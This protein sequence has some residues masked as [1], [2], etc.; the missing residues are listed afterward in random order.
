[1]IGRGSYTILGPLGAGGMGEVYRARDSKLGRDVAIKILPPHLLDDQERRARFTREA[2]LLATLNHPH[3]GAIYG[4]E[5]AQGLTALVLE[6]VEGLTLAGHLARGPLPIADAVAIA[7]QI[8]E[9]LEAAHHKGIVHRDLKPANIALHSST[10]AAGIPSSVAFVKVLDFGLAKT[11]A[12]GAHE[13]ITQASFDATAEGRVLGTPA[14]MSPEQARGQGVDKRTDIWAF[15]CVLYEMLTGR[16]AFD[17]DTLSDTFVSILE[18]EPDWTALPAQTPA[19]VRLLLQR[20]LRKDPGRRLHDIADARIELE[21]SEAPA[22][23][24]SPTAGAAPGRSRQRQLAWLTAALVTVAVL[25]A[26]TIAWMRW[27]RAPPAADRVEFV[28]APPDGWDFTGSSFAIAP[29]GRHVV[30]V[31]SSRGTSLL[32]IRAI[33]SSGWRQLA[34]TEGALNPFWSPDSQAIGFFANHKLRTVRTSGELPISLCDARSF[35]NA[36]GAWSS[37]G[38]I[39]FGVEDVIQQVSSRG[40]KPTTVTRL[41]NG[42]TAHRWPAFL[43]DGRHFLYLAQRPGLNELR[44]GSLTSDRT[45]SLGRSES[46]ARYDGDRLVFVRGGA[47]MAQPFDVSTFK[48]KGDAVVIANEVAVVDPTARGVFS[49]SGGA[50]AYSRVG[51]TMNQLTWFDRKGQPVGTIGN[52]GFHIN[53]NLSPDNRRLAA[54]LL[55]EQPDSQSNVDIWIIDLAR[56]ATPQRIT[57]HPAREFDP[58]WSPDGTQVAFTSDRTGEK[59]SLYVRSSSG[60]GEDQLLVKSETVITTPDWSRD[61]VIMF[62]ER[63]SATQSDLWTLSRSG[64]RKRSVFLQTAYDELAAAFSPDGR[65]IAYESNKSGRNE[66]YVRPFPVNEQVL[67][68]SRDGGR[69]PRWR[70]DGRELFFLAPDGTVMTAAT[71]TTGDL[72]AAVAKP[73][74]PTGS[75]FTGNLRPYAVTR[76]G[77]RFLIPVPR[78]EPD[79]ITVVLNWPAAVDK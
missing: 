9:A 38:V 33:A 74:F 57:D 16:R 24:A 37:T 44:V 35:D 26:I 78:K 18:R 27:H 3:I 63:G 66:V 4:L 28:V 79:S 19:S 77:Q 54:S 22:R 49:I 56:V 59:N 40:G 30:A 76:D 55:T 15:G 39:I 60:S 51:R 1:M 14:Y 11:L 23:S 71:D 17:G 21:E 67:P 58:V 65:W 32:W 12:A 46:D 25:G 64:E 43:P 75:S 73:L 50:L 72:T 5:E 52:P 29:D 42:D 7:R 53:L 61:D 8:A 6:L 47:L 2:R 31:A 48:T 45:E 70:A 34:G 68:I 20:C 41:V 69:A 62:S 10:N 36:G 13:D